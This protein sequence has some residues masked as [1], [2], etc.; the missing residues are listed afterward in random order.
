M[1]TGIREDLCAL[2]AMEAV[3]AMR[4]GRLPAEKYAAALLERARECRHLNAFLAL[5]SGVV[6]E[7]A[8]AADRALAAGTPPGLL[9]GLPIPVKDSV[10]TRLLK[11]TNGTRALREFRP[12]DDAPV[13]K[14]LFAQGAILMGKTNLQELSRG[15][16]SNNGAFGAVRN[17]RDPTRVPGGSSGGS[18]A[19]VA[20]GIAPLAVAEDTWGSIRVPAAMCGTAGLRPT[21]GRYPN[22]G[23]MPLTLGLFDQVG[24]LA[25]SVADLALFDAAVTGEAQV[26]RAPPLAGLRLG[27]P[28]EFMDGLDPEV[29][30]VVG[31]AFRRLQAAGVTLV[32]AALPPQARDCAEVAGTIIGFENVAAIGAFL[33]REG[34]GVDFEAL[35]AQASPNIRVRYDSTPPSRHEYESALADRERLIAALPAYYAAHRIEALV[36]PPVLAPAPPLGDNPEVRIGDI[37]VPLRVV[38]GRNTALGNC[39]GLSSL[40]LPAGFTSSRLPAA[41]ELDALPGTD[42]RLLGLGLALE[43][44]LGFHASPAAIDGRPRPMQAEGS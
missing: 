3:R 13:L 23:I 37:E 18:A 17:P 31:E 32:H 33:A 29:E 27:V 38:V 7:A 5:D 19:A 15:W 20:A 36:F 42:R 35:I 2:T 22:D 9:H 40:V 44:A 43:R 1:G 6:M 21:V 12:R 26:R 16:T 11:T 8:R 14:R 34:A 41:L 4:E 28:I 25:R 39:A 24:P 30:R 10:N